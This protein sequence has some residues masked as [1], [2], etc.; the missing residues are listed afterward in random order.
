MAALD[1][2]EDILWFGQ[3][4]YLV[5]KGQ[6]RI[7]EQ[8]LATS[9]RLLLAHMD[10][11]TSLV[12]AKLAGGGAGAVLHKYRQRCIDLFAALA[13][14]SF[15]Q[16]RDDGFAAC[17]NEAF[18]SQATRKL[19]RQV[20]CVLR[21]NTAFCQ[22]SSNVLGGRLH[23]KCFLDQMTRQQQ[24]TLQNVMACVNFVSGGL[25]A[26]VQASLQHQALV[27][28]YTPP[29]LTTHLLR[30]PGQLHV[31]LL[32]MFAANQVL[33]CKLED[34]ISMTEQFAAFNIGDYVYRLFSSCRSVSWTEGGASLK[35]Q[36]I[37]NMGY[38]IT[39]IGEVYSCK[40]VLNRCAEL[41]RVDVRA[42]QARFLL[43]ACPSPG[44]AAGGYMAL[45]GTQNG[46]ALGDV[47]S[48]VVSTY[49]LA[50]QVGA[51]PCPHTVRRLCRRD[52]YAYQDSRLFADVLGVVEGM[53]SA[54]AQLQQLRDRYQ[55]DA[56]STFEKRVRYQQQRQLIVNQ[57]ALFGVQEQ[58]ILTD[59]EHLVQQHLLGLHEGRG[60]H[61]QPRAQVP[62]ER[63]AYVVCRKGR[64]VKQLL[65]HK[66]Q[67]VAVLDTQDTIRI[68][69]LRPYAHLHYL[70][71]Q[72]KVTRKRL[73]PSGSVY[74]S[75]NCL[76]GMLSGA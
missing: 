47:Y 68:F 5:S 75:H 64:G 12:S 51:G 44:P 22:Q 73:V 45:F 50:Q 18:Q 63:E 46:H 72:E 19:L 41:Q 74:V 62:Q 49:R 25:G 14:L 3:S 23:V 24:R 71:R 36:V 33:L 43:G 48:T 58:V 52:Q 6:R 7:L 30:H 55:Q 28:S 66:D 11:V 67:Y 8:H 40:L 56:R 35:G 65:V 61:E 38:E 32:N 57:P 2:A 16:R 27:V 4:L 59:V 1:S 69:N 15:R 10:C 21:T 70:R 53:K 39:S 42:L 34:A 76:E 9:R 37:Q 20:D 13:H 31:F 26:G 54:Q 29:A 17:L 60:R